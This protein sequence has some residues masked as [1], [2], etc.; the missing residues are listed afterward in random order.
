MAKIFGYWTFSRSLS[1]PDFGG[2]ESPSAGSW[3]GPI[4]MVDRDTRHLTRFEFDLALMLKV[5]PM[6]A[7]P[8]DLARLIGDLPSRRSHVTIGQ[9]M[10]SLARLEALGLVSKSETPPRPVRGGRRRFLY[11]LETSGARA[12]EKTAAHYRSSASTEST[13]ETPRSAV[14]APA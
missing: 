10:K 13:H 5:H 8:S 1:A 3:E 7:F 9:V 12:L 14:L 2:G 11:K 6:D 4:E